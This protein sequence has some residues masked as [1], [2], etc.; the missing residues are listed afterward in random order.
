VKSLFSIG[1]EGRIIDGVEARLRANGAGLVFDLGAIPWRKRHAF[2]NACAKALEG[3]GST[4]R[5][6]VSLGTPKSMPTRHRR[7]HDFGECNA[8]FD[9]YFEKQVVG[10]SN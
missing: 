8:G 9:K 6:R 1:Y 7:D 10:C 3:V 4:Y 2:P 5:H